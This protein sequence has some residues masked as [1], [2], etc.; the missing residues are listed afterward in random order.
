[1]IVE[2]EPV[3]RSILK[4][5]IDYV[6]F[7]QLKKECKNGTEAYS[8][9][10]QEEDVDL[11]FLDM[12]IFRKNGLSFLKTLKKVPKIIITSAYRK[13]A[14]EGFD[15]GVTDFL[16]KPLSFDKFLNAVNKATGRNNSLSHNN[17]QMPDYVTLESGKKKFNVLISSILY[18]QGMSNYVKVI[19]TNKTLFIYQR[20]RDLEVQLSEFKFLRIHKSYI[21]PLEKVESYN[22]KQVVIQEKPISIGYSYRKTVDDAMKKYTHN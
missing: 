18:I 22:S 1:M 8:Y 7:L 12:E 19:T 15:L 2:D 14:Y 21:I 11:F 9:I 4:K 17:N 13:Y 3:A 5:Y 16:Q 10:Q 20:L 6:H